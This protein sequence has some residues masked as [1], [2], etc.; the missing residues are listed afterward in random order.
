MENSVSVFETSL[1]RSASTRHSI[2]IVRKIVRQNKKNLNM[3]NSAW[4]GKY[5][6]ET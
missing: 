4:S 5:H 3:E 6:F 1:T 2:Q